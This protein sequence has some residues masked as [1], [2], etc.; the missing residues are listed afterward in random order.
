MVAVST[1][2]ARQFLRSLAEDASASGLSLLDALKAAGKSRITTL[3]NGQRVRMT[4]GNGHTVELESSDSE[5]TPAEIAEMI[6]ELRDRYEEGVER[7][8]AT[9]D[10]TT[11][12]NILSEMLRKL[13]PVRS[14][15]GD[16]SNLRIPMGEVTE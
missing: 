3:A 9:G 13:S 16:F 10:E 12:A 8:S 2:F 15:S 4:S 11:D 5:V 7:L 14:Y 6:S 1:P